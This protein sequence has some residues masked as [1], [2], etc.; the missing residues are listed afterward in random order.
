MQSFV[1][2][3][4]SEEALTMHPVVL[5]ATAHFKLV[6]QLTCPLCWVFYAVH[7]G[8]LCHGKGL[9]LKSEGEGK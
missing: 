1:K 7:D 4:N 5:A 3:L 6:S 2:W 8:H 9:N